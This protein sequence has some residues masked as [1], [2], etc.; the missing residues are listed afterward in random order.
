M[1]TNR[2]VVAGSVAVL[3]LDYFLS[4]ILLRVLPAVQK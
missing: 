3:S 2:A 4:D 1:G